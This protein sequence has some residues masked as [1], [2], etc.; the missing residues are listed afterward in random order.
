MW[1]ARA[2]GCAG[3]AVPVAAAPRT[4]SPARTSG[5]LASGG[6]RPADGA[7]IS[8]VGYSS[9]SRRCYGIRMNRRSRCAGLRTVR[10]GETSPSAGSGVPR[11]RRQQGL[12]RVLGTPALFATA[13]GNVGSSIYYALGVT[14]AIALGL[15]PLVF[16]ISG[17]D[18][19]GTAAT[20]AEGT[21]LLPGGRR[22]VELRAARVQ[23]ARLVRGGVG[24]DAQLRHHGRHLGV[25]RAALP[26]DLLGAAAD[27]PVGHHRRHRRRSSCSSLLNIVGHP[28]GGEPEH[29]PRGRRLRDA[30][31]ARRARLRRSIFSPHMLTSNVHWGVAPTWANFALAIPVAMIAYTGIETVSNLA[32]EARDPVALD[33]ERDP[34]GRDRRVRDL[35]HAAARRALGAAG[36]Q[37]RERAVRDEARAAAR[38]RA[39]SRT[40]RCS[41]SSR[42][43][44]CTARCSAARRSTSASSRRRSSSS[45]RTPA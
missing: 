41:G 4:S 32:E 3:V 18:L 38:S 20:Y 43:S 13:Y 19:R 44:A 30:A 2:L 5:P 7:R 6:T 39:A 45:R 10:A 40:T 16:V 17:A 34:L 25:L 9:S 14:A 42:T 11:R 33:P 35:L 23:R 29:L 21:V 27:E 15:T 36:V 26:V 22:L 12:E 1:R 24:A 31:A 8:K 37:G 28:G